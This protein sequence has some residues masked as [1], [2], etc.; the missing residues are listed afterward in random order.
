MP[1]GQVVR[2]EFSSFRLYERVRVFDL[3]DRDDSAVI[4]DS[5]FGLNTRY[6]EYSGIEPSFNF[7]SAG[8]ELSIKIN[9]EAGHTGPGFIANYAAIPAGEKHVVTYL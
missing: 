5:V 9:G 7:F 2:I 8:N 4:A 6:V 1:K 3:Y